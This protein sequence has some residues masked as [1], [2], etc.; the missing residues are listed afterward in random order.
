MEMKKYLILLISIMLFACKKGTVTPAVGITGSWQWVS[1]KGG[2]G[3]ISYTPASTG[4][5]FVLQLNA[6]SSYV[7]G[8][9]SGKFHIGVDPLYLK[10]LISFSGSLSAEY[11]YMPQNILVSA[12]TLF[13]NDADVSDAFY[14]RYQRVK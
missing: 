12:D 2:I 9:Q 14:S 13:L 5:N 7:T 4:K 10:S 6:D 11:L 1:T 3:G 8:Q